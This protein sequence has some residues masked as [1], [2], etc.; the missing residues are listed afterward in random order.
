MFSPNRNR[1][2]RPE[3][4]ERKPLSSEKKR[5]LIAVAIF[6]VVLLAIYYGSMSLA[7]QNPARFGFLV[8][9]VMAIYMAAFAV[10]LVV[11]LCYNR[12]FVNKNVTEEMLPDEWD[13]E[14]KQAFV[15]GNRIR[16]EK[17]RWMLTLIIPFIVVFMVEAFYLFVWNGW[18]GNFFSRL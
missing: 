4:K 8:Y 3:R 16:A 13:K 12:A 11:Y 2:A 10:L 1:S 15:E 14:K 6:T 17:S 9:G 7:Q 18:L 5:Q